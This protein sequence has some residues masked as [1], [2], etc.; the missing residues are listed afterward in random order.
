MNRWY[1]SISFIEINLQGKQTPSVYPPHFREKNGERRVYPTRMSRA[2]N[3][4]A[5]QSGVVNA[6]LLL[7]RQILPSR[8]ANF[9]W[10]K[11]SPV[12][13]G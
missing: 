2:V 9:G 5:R 12:Y 11:S 4:Y 3:I 13:Q 7:G 8:H 6:S 10:K 1:I